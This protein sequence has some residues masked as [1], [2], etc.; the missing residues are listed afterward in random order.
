MKMFKYVKFTKVEDEFTTHTFRGGDENVKVNHFDIDV[1][2]LESEDE[3]AITETIISQDER[4]N[5]EVIT[6]EEFKDLVSD[7]AQINRI[8][9]VVKER[10]ACKYSAADEIAMLK[11]NADDKKKIAYETYV[12][13]CIAVGDELKSLVGY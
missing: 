11:R 2:S 4:I 5:C 12:S 10:I 7:S 6:K 9:S 3:V 1:V 8:R 13:E